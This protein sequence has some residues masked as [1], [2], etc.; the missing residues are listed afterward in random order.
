MGSRSSSYSSRDEI[1]HAASAP[2]Q[3]PSDD[4]QDASHPVV[5][6]PQ[7]LRRRSSSSDG[8]AIQGYPPMISTQR[9]ST[10]PGSFTSV[11]SRTSSCS[12]SLAQRDRRKI[13]PAARA[14]M[15]NANVVAMANKRAEPGP[16]DY[17]FERHEH[18]GAAAYSA[19]SFG[20]RTPQRP[21]LPGETTGRID[22]AKKDARA[23]DIASTR[24]VA[25]GWNTGS[26][27][28]DSRDASF[29]SHR[30]SC[31]NG[32][33]DGYRDGYGYSSTSPCSSST[34]SLP[35]SPHLANRLVHFPAEG[36]AEGHGRY[37]PQRRPSSPG[38]VPGRSPAAGRPPSP[39]RPPHPHAG[40]PQRHAGHGPQGPQAQLAQM[41]SETHGV[42]HTDAQYRAGR[43]PPLCYSPASSPDRQRRYS[44]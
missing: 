34:S 43:P 26:F 24:T 28:S 8:G 3:Q 39:G 20:S 38:R 42:L 21:V 19:H 31:R 29:A 18:P 22:A 27:T 12:S 7:L 10:S 44:Q 4:G 9:R 2:L 11:S 41:Y 30:D 6:A 36:P 25:K 16:G 17:A 37:S 15:E 23:V 33:R 40:H 13:S 1:A 35:A 5:V 14:V 32:Y